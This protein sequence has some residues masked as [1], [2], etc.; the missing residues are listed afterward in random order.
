LPDFADEKFEEEDGD[1]DKDKEDEDVDEAG[2]EPAG[3]DRQDST[4]SDDVKNKPL[5]TE[6]DDQEPNDKAE[7]EGTEFDGLQV[8]LSS[9][10]GLCYKLI[11]IIIDAAR[12]DAPNWSITLMIVIDVAS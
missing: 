1:E 9:I 7:D 3:H 4:P 2:D 8:G 12:S 6:Q 5:T 10:R 11:T